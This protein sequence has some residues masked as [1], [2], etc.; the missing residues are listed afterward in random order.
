MMKKITAF[1]FAALIVVSLFAG[2]AAKD[3]GKFIVGLDDSFPPMGFRDENNEIV[4][5]DIDLAKEVAKRLNMEFVAQPIDWDSKELE[6][7]NGNVSCIWNGMTITDERKEAM[8]ISDPY[9]AN[10]QIIVVAPG[11]DIT[12]SADLAGKV[13]GLQKGS[14]AVA[15]L[16]K[17]E[18]RAQIKEVVEYTDNVLA[19]TDLKVGRT[20]AVVVDEVVGRYYVAKAADDYVVLEES[21]AP[22]EYGIGFDKGNTELCEKVNK[23]LKEMKE[24]GTTAK[25]SEKWFGKDIIMQ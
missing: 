3:N 6:L 4:G 25:I 12:S 14:S 17:T 18:V 11:S 15:A 20:D 23:A 2:C 19:L 24:D 8:L 9:M 13:V 21:L 5:V 1:L 7:K 16:D 10:N 22:E